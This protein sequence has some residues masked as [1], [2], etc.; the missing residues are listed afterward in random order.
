MVLKPGRE[1]EAE[2]IFKKWE[3]DFAVIGIT[4]DTSRLVVKHKAQVV[5]DM[6][7]TAL[8]DEAPVYERPYTERKP[9]TG[10]PDLRQED[11]M[12]WPRS[13]RMLGRARHG[14]APL[15]VGAVR[16]HRD[17][18]HRAGAGRRRRRGARAW[19]AKGAGHHHRCQP[20]L[21]PRRSVRR[22]Q[23]GRGRSLAQPDRRGRDAAGGH[24]QSELRQSAKPEI[25]GEIVAGIDGIGA[26]CRALDFP[27]IGGNVLALQ[28][29]QRRR[30]PAH[31]RHRRRRPDA[32]RQQ[33][34]DRSP[35]S[36]RVT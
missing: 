7:V 8:S 19:H 12:C 10:E 36:V 18:R 3:L 5:A 17:G 28:R 29:D 25:M 9:Q 23:A 2:A 33:D 20:A 26:A 14:L 35:S 22:R 11:R 32:G 13:R 31:P 6:P 16:P 34:G 15:G 27:V 30:H 4:T 21:L 1:A 24:R